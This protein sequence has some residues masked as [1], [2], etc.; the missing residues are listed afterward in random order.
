MEHSTEGLVCVQGGKAYEIAQIRDILQ[1]PET[2]IAIK[3]FVQQ[4]REI[5]EPIPFCIRY[6]ACIST[7]I[8]AVSTVLFLL[9]FRHSALRLREL[10]EEHFD[11]VHGARNP[12][13]SPGLCSLRS[14]ICAGWPKDPSTLNEEDVRL[15]TG[16]KRSW[17]L[18]YAFLNKLP[19][20]IG[21]THW[22]LREFALSEHG[23]WGRSVLRE[24]HVCIHH[25][26]GRLDGWCDLHN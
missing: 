12:F 1:D 17:V 8:A 6:A 4:L 5:W 18:D 10:V 11:P 3:C 9:H 26:L 19:S 24:H 7:C 25:A 13:S 14:V 15:L 16:G 20:F 23:V 22:I 21:A 2:G